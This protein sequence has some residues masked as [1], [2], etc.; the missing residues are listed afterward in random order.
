MSADPAVKSRTVEV[1][2]VAD[3]RGA[4][5]RSV[6]VGR[7]R[8]VAVMA[9][10]EVKVFFGSCPH[11]GGPLEKGR[12][13]TELVSGRPGELTLLPESQ[14]LRCPWHGYEFELHGGRAITDHD[15]CL[16]FVPSTVSDGKVRV[17]WPPPAAERGHVN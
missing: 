8:L 2:D 17:L 5:I 6:D 11:Q 1:C 12:M 14:L 7:A 16:R 9:A 4:Q 3:L 10:G 15:V 13:V